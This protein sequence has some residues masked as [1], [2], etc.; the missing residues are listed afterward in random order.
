MAVDP[1]TGDNHSGHREP[2]KQDGALERLVKHIEPPGHEVSTDDL[3]DPGRMTP[4]S[5]RTD[6]RS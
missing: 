5:R 6:N 2:D 3:K 1:K 4:D